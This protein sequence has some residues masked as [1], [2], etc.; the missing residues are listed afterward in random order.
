MAQ[1]G[2]T[3]ILIYASGTTGH[4]PLAADLTSG[5]S[6][7]ELALNY[8]DGKLFY[9]D[10]LGNVKYF[11]SGAGVSSLSFGTTGLTPSTSSTGAITVAGTLATTNGGT[12]LTSFTANGIP[13]ASS[14][15]ALTTGSSLVFDGSNL[16]VGTSSPNSYGANYKVIQVAGTNGGI[17]QATS[18]TVIAEVQGDSSSAIGQIGTRSNHSVMF[19]T[20]D[21]ER[22]RIDSSGIVGVGSVTYSTSSTYDQV[23]GARQ[24]TVVG[25]DSSTTVAGSLAAMTIANS[26]TTTSNSSQINFAAVTGASTNLY[27]SAVI[28][29]V[30]GGRTNGQYPT[31]QLIFSTSSTLNSAPSEKMR[32]LAG[33]D[34]YLTSGSLVSPPTA[35]NDFVAGGLVINPTRRTTG[36]S[37]NTFW[38]SGTGQF[39]RS[40]SSLRY[41]DN[42]EDAT[43]GLAEVL[44]LRPVTYS[45]KSEVDTGK[46]FG[47]FIAEEVD[48]IGLTE[49]VVY[50]ADGNPDALGYDR[51]VSVLCKAIQ[52]LNVKV[53]TLEEQVVALEAK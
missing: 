16:G 38:D 44:Q 19:K 49:F 7:A 8:A 2:F 22:M 37:G 14:T 32:I 35:G 42:I 24:F 17:L 25:S 40:T 33:G 39:Y 52:E 15:S 48:A 29:C 45:G 18:G 27:S 23:A 20:N 53:T 9:K 43:H 51:M 31:G 6:G 30:F 50:D 41:K 26:N 28:S 10:N 12:G 46:R 11:S 47:G 36:S 1:T 3:P 5:A 4:T 34:M 13:Y 21:T